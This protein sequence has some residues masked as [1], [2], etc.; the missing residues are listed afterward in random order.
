MTSHHRRPDQILVALGLLTR[1]PG[2]RPGQIAPTVWSFPV[3]GIITGTLQAV[4]AGITL[5][6]GL[7]ESVAAALAIM[8]GLFATGA[9]HEDGLAD[10]ADGL[11]GGSTKSRRLE[12]MRDSHLGSYGA[13]ALICSLGL[14]GAALTALFAQGYVW[15]PLITAAAASRAAIGPVMVKL[16]HARS[17]GLS[18]HVGHAT[19]NDALIGLAIAF[20]VSVLLTGHG[21][22]GI[23]LACAAVTAAMA[24]IALNKIEGQSGDILGAVQQLSQCAALIALCAS[25][26]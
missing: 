5:W 15:A 22:V 7:P 23:A 20:A 4:A 3:V 17:D 8:A 2:G 26:G 21:V 25:L 1:L 12:I 13:L 14:Q 6:F 24:R 16:P 18:H 10:T 19:A 9:L 11:W